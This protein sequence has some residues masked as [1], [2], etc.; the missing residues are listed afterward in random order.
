MCRTLTDNNVQP[1]ID[2]V[3]IP[4]VPVDSNIT[5]GNDVSV[6]V[7]PLDI[8]TSTTAS[9]SSKEMIDL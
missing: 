4:P 3:A 1:V 6:T 5:I 9:I 8:T 2:E 7:E